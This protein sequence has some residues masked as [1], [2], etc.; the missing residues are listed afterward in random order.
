MKQIKKKSKSILEFQGL[1]LNNLKSIYGG[2]GDGDIDPPKPT[3]PTGPG[4]S[5][6]PR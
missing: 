3:S 5:N 4:T 1:K 6:G 2:F